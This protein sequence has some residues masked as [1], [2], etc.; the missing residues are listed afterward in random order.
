LE[1]S[2]PLGDAPCP[3]CGSLLWFARTDAGV[4]CYE[5]DVIAPIR[6]RLLEIISNNLGVDR[7]GIFE[8]TPIEEIGADSLDVV[9]L[10]M[11]LEEDFRLQVSDKEAEK[12]R[13]VRD[14]IAVI[15]RHEQ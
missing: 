9:E 14:L 2:L 15:A 7:A 8:S 1:A 12:I 6:E 11:K 3:N 10:L 5:S 4:L 13:T